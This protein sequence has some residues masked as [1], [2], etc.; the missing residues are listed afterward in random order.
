[1]LKNLL[2]IFS[3]GSITLTIFFGYVLCPIFS[4]NNN[5]NLFNIFFYY[6]FTMLCWYSIYVIIEGTIEKYLTENRNLFISNINTKE[7]IKEL[8]QKIS[9]N[10]YTLILI[11]FCFFYILFSQAKLVHY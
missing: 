3:N 6:P 1:M 9:D 8:T 7:N 5:S 10:L 11:A 2:K 4:D